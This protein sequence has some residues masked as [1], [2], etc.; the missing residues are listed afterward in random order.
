MIARYMFSN[1]LGEHIIYQSP[2]QEYVKTLFG[3]DQMNTN[4]HLTTPNSVN[5]AR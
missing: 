2:P 5:F 4:Y 3:D 1:P